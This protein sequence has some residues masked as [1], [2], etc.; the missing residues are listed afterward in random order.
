MQTL[1]PLYFRLLGDDFGRLD[2]LLQR[3]HSTPGLA[4]RGETRVAWG[5]QPLLRTLLRLGRLPREGEAQPV[6]V[7]LA[8]QGGGEC[9]QRNFAGRR[10]HSHQH[11]DAAGLVESFGPWSLRLDN[12]VEAG[13]LHQ[14]SRTTRCLGLPLPARLGLRVLAREWAVGERFH[15]D[16]AIGWGRWPLLHY[17]GWLLAQE[18]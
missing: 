5:E 11:A 7:V 2:P 4:W 6:E 12:Q 9:W 1:S 17:T 16:V 8:E 13:T 15:F 3:F 10:M 14:I 18:D